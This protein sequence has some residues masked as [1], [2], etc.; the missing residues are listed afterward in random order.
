[1]CNKVK[2]LL[3][4]KCGHINLKQFYNLQYFEHKLLHI[5]L[6]ILFFFLQYTL[7]LVHMTPNIQTRFKYLKLNYSYIK[8]ECSVS[9]LSARLQAAV[10]G[11][12][13]TIWGGHILA[14]TNAQT[15]SNTLCRLA[16]AAAAVL[17]LSLS[18]SFNQH[19]HYKFMCKW[20]YETSS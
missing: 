18:L 7:K 8:M 9:T 5:H 10:T 2:L 20:G 19:Y 16:A 15:L 6:S 11:E 13:K 1:M 3:Q 4:T 17:S 14:S 12:W